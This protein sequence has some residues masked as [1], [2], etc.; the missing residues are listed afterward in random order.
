MNQYLN[1]TSDMQIVSLYERELEAL[2]NCNCIPAYIYVCLCQYFN[3]F[4]SWWHEFFCDCY[5]SCLTNLFL[6]EETISVNAH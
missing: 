6:H 1:K 4:S 3:V 5:I 2:F